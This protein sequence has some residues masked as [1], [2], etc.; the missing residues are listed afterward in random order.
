[1]AKQKLGP[2]LPQDGLLF[3]KI[4]DELPNNPTPIIH[5]LPSMWMQLSTMDFSCLCTVPHTIQ[6]ILSD[7]MRCHD[8]KLKSNIIT[9]INKYI[10]FNSWLYYTWFDS[11]AWYHSL[12]IL[13][14]TLH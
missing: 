14:N 6:Y 9:L 3:P 4:V 1:M 10:F 11:S 12:Y 13:L 2:S 8:I 7:S 5:P